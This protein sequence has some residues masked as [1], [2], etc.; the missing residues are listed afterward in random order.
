MTFLYSLRLE[1]NL[2]FVNYFLEF[3]AAM[4]DSKNLD[5]IRGGPK[6]DEVVAVGSHDDDPHSLE[7]WIWRFPSCAG[8]WNIG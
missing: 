3:A 1:F 5:G 2:D 6:E 8:S 7:R 4:N